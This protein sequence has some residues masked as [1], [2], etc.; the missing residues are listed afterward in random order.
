MHLYFQFRAKVE[1]VIPGP[2]LVM[3]WCTISGYNIHFYTHRHTLSPLQLSGHF[4]L[5]S[6]IFQFNAQHLS[7]SVNARYH[8]FILSTTYLPSDTNQINLWQKR[9][10]LFTSTLQENTL[11]RGWRHVKWTYINVDVGLWTHKRQRGW[12][13]MWLL[14]RC[15]VGSSWAL[16]GCRWSRSST[17]PS[18]R[19]SPPSPPGHRRGVRSGVIFPVPSAVWCVMCYVGLM[20]RVWLGSKTRGC[21]CLLVPI[22]RVWWTIWTSLVRVEDGD[23]TDIEKKV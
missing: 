7:F 13:D 20:D 1:I 4:T 11:T 22:L 23:T 2:C 19:P 21:G 5:M 18:P 15:S 12:H 3:V 6:S 9:I 17:R 14:T 10:N 8:H 16:C